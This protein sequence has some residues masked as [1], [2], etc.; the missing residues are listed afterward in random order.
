MAGTGVG[1]GRQR[2][3]GGGTDGS[4]PGPDIMSDPAERSKS[5]PF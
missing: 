5:E 1:E 3:A 4:P 2:A